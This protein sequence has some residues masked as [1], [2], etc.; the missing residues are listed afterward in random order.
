MSQT[1]VKLYVHL[2]FSTKHRLPLITPEIES[3]LHGY[4]TGIV[5]GMGCKLVRI[6]GVADHVHMLVLLSKNLALSELL[7]AVKKDSSKWIK[8]QGEYRDFHWQEGYAGFSVSESGVGRC[9]SYINNQK[10]HHA[11]ASFKEE[12]L[13]LLKKYNLEYD[14]RYLWD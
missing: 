1:L 2:V 11:R 13:M 4:M 3:G 14:E 5:Q 10:K 6:G 7:Q 8:T 9:I 12:L